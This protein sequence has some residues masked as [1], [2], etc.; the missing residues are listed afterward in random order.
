MIVVIHMLYMYNTS[1]F[2]KG[3]PV[4]FTKD[5]LDIS[6]QDKKEGEKLNLETYPLLQVEYPLD[7]LR[8]IPNFQ[9]QYQCLSTKTI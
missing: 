4:L 5:M 8:S 3:K 2:I 6:E 9:D 1:N 7:K